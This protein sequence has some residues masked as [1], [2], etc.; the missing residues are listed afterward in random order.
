M[1]AF[2]GLSLVTDLMT[3]ASGMSHELLRGERDY[4]LVPRQMPTWRFG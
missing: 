1:K 2:V 4:F 3:A